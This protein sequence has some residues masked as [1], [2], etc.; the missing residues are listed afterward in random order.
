[1]KLRGEKDELEGE[2]ADLEKTLGS[3]ARMQ[4][5]IKKEL[6]AVAADYG[7]DRRT[8]L[9]RSRGITGL[10]RRRPD[11]QRSHHGGVIHQGLGASSQGSRRESLMSLTIALAM[12]LRRRPKA[13]PTMCWF[14]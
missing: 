12:N 3:K 2:K 9:N 13:A 10:Q 11:D 8:P 14:S 6:L 1:M 4:T 7:D 5:L